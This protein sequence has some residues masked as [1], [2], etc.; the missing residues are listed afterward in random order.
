MVNQRVV[1]SALAIWALSCIP[2]ATA[3]LWDVCTTDVAGVKTCHNTLSRSA[4]IN[5]A[6]ACVV[7]LL[8][9]LF[10]VICVM[11]NRRVRAA[12]E[13]EYNVEANQ[14]DGPP[15]I[16]ATEYNPTSGPSGIYEGPKS[17]FSAGQSSAQMTGPTYPVAAQVYNQNRTAPVSQ[18]SFPYPFPGYPSHAGPAPQTSFVS[19]GFPRA[20]LAGDRLKDRLKERP[21]SPA[22]SLG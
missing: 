16:I 3:T 18:T 13:Q 17:G 6:I 15:T 9:V 19:G 21:A 1:S 7:V 10:L 14:V 11:N 8:V 5:I 12:S 22:H 2:T 20:M 4:K